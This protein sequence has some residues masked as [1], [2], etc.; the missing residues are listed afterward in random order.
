MSQVMGQV[1]QCHLR[2]CCRAGQ[3]GADGADG[4]LFKPARSDSDGKVA[5]LLPSSLTGT[6]EKVVFETING[7]V[8]EEG[9]YSGG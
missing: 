2:I 7:E 6:I 3:R 4:F 1:V 9:R 5:V 8:L